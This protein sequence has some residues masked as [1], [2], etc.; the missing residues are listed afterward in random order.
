M[1]VE[2]TSDDEEIKSRFKILGVIFLPSM[3][4]LLCVVALVTGIVIAVA[5]TLVELYLWLR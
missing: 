5:V 1:E 3:L 4:L 2:S